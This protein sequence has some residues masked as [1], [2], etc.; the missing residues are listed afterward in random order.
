MHGAV[1]PHSHKGGD[2]PRIGFDQVLG[3]TLILEFEPGITGVNP[4]ENPM[5]VKLAREVEA[6][7]ATDGGK[8]NAHI[9]KT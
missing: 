7:K 6:V 2:N 3:E 9:R 5:A 8:D 4:F 1:P